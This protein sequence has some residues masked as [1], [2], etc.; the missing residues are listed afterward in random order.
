MSKLP[1]QEK[2]VDRTGSG[3]F[4]EVYPA[5]AL[6]PWNI[7]NAKKAETASLVQAIVKRTAGW[8]TVPD[9]VRLKCRDNRDACDALIASLVARAAAL[10][11][12]EPIPEEHRAAAN[13]EG[14]IALPLRGSLEV[15]PDGRRRD[16]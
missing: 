10:S 16:G 6:R 1:W 3:K 12:C 5:A 2:P 9:D 8:L 14:W 7:P 15:L 11:L 13:R 4:V